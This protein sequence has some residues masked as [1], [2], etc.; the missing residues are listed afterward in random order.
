VD[1]EDSLR[2]PLKTLEWIAGASAGLY[3]KAVNVNLNVYVHVHVNVYVD[4]EHPRLPA[5]VGLAFLC[6]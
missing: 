5:A 4:E 2:E 1:D 3:G 6:S